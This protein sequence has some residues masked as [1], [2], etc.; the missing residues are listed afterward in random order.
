MTVRDFEVAI[1]R[2]DYGGITAV[3]AKASLIRLAAARRRR[4][5]ARGHFEKWPSD[6]TAEHA[7]RT[8]D[9]FED[10]EALASEWNGC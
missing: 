5:S 4:D 7:R 9:A 3:H 6:V 8:Q 1:G 10:Q 2:A